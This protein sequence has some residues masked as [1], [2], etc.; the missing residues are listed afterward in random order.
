MNDF[1]VRIERSFDGRIGYSVWIIGYDDKFSKTYIAKPMS[2]EF[3]EV[4]EGW[5]LPEP[6]LRLND[7]S[8]RILNAFPEGLSEAGIVQSRELGQDK[9]IQNMKEEIEQLRKWIDKLL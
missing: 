6:S 4:K 5:R 7:E 2:I 9:L 8:S 3:V 1:K